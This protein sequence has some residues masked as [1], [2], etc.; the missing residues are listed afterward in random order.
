[1]SQPMTFSTDETPGQQEW[2]TLAEFSLPS[3]PGN[4][5]QAMGL[6]ADVVSGLPIA[7]A[8]MERLKTAVAE[9]ALNAMEHGNKFRA[10]LPADIQVLLSLAGDALMVR[11]TDHGGNKQPI[12]DQPE[13]DLE[14]KLAG[15]QSPRGWGLFLIKSMVDEM[16]VINEEQ[17]HTVELIFNLKGEEV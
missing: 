15:L 2:R 1:M 10:E 7:P 4:E 14:A 11:I 9:T 5:R 12:P 13:P 6:V 16:R 8:R 17:R 3:E